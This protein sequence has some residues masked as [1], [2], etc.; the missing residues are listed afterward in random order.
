[1]GL[2]AI[3]ANPRCVG[4]SMTGM[5]DHGF[6][7]EGAT[8][9]EFRELKPGAT[10]ALFDGFAPLRFC[11]FV[12]PV[13][14]YRGAKVRLDA[15]LAN[16]DAMPPGEY[17]VRLQ[18]VGPDGRCVLQK[19]LTVKIADPRSNPP[20]PLANALLGQEIAV[21]GPSGQYRF[22]ATPSEGRRGGGR[23]RRV[24]CGR[25]GR[26]A[27]S[28]NRGRALG[29]RCGARQ[30][31]GRARHQDPTLRRRGQNAREV[32][33]VGQRPA[34][35]DAAAWR[36]LAQHIARGSSAVFLCPG[37]F[38]KKDNPVAWVPLV[39]KGNWTARADWLYP[40]DSWTRK[41]PIFDGLPC[42]NLM[43]YIFYRE[44]ISNDRWVGLDAPAETVAAS[45][46]ASLRIRFGDAGF[47][48]R[49]GGG[50][51]HPQH[52]GHSPQPG[53]RS[54]CRAVV[55][56]PAPLCCPRRH[57]A[58]GRIAGQFRGATQSDGIE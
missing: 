37:V 45:I 48:A 2:N 15:V 55:A 5:Y 52:V 11:L 30:M 50:P 32:I 1:M 29:R 24:L 17:P 20:P 28:G 33:L 58:A 9:S 46:N 44:L 43:D 49:I 12:E 51:V 26:H 4:H 47:G 7:G 3:R 8:A 21:D 18:I 23:K 22:L 10:D 35:G 42:G 14:V 27:E 54:A 13:N 38:A 36:S 39:N 25:S 53:R 31:A 34:G 19:T 40:H 56:E 16:E 6:C 41:H 57:P